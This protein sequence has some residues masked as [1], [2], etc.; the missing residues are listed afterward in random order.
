MNDHHMHDKLAN[1]CHFFLWIFLLQT[2]YFVSF[3]LRLSWLFPHLAFSKL[4]QVEKEHDLNADHSQFCGPSD[5]P[6]VETSSVLFEQKLQNGSIYNGGSE[7]NKSGELKKLDSFG[8]WLDKEIGGDCDDSLMASD[9]GNYWNTLNAPN[10]DKEVSSLQMQLDMDSLG[11]SL[12]QEQLFTFHEFSPDW[13]YSGVKTKVYAL[14][15]YY[16]TFLCTCLHSPCSCI[17][18]NSKFKN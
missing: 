7:H 14:L 18:K 1:L 12:S 13:A 10:G 5:H 2:Y 11:P 8:R 3:K 15:L 6:A 16:I 9:S 4:W 17:I